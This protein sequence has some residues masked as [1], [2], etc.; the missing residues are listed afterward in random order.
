[1]NA[2]LSRRSNKEVLSGRGKLWRRIINPIERSISQI[3]GFNRRLNLYYI[4]RFRILKEEY[5]SLTTSKSGIDVRFELFDPSNR[6]IKQLN[7]CTSSKSISN[8]CLMFIFKQCGPK[9]NNLRNQERNSTHISSVSEIQSSIRQ[10]IVI[11]SHRGRQ[12]CG[13]IEQIETLHI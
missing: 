11:D 2:Q 13:E 6:N 4:L 3:E 1:M 8:L 5:I 12:S 7:Q 10:H 9:S